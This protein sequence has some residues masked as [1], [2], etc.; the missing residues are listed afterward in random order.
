[1]AAGQMRAGA[2][3]SRFPFLNDCRYRE[4]GGVPFYDSEAKGLVRLL[5]VLND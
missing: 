4:A 3:S 2:P 1:M 5:P